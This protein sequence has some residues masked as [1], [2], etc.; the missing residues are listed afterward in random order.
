LL[1]DVELGGVLHLL[2]ELLIEERVSEPL[3]PYLLG[4]L[5]VRRS[6]IRLAA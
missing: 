2:V 5:A 3:I 6:S 1:A 4:F